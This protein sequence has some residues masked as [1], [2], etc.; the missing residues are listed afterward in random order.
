MNTL[1]ALKRIQAGQR[2]GHEH[3][4]QQCDSSLHKSPPSR[5]HGSA[6]LPGFPPRPDSGFRS[7]LAVSG[8]IRKRTPTVSEDTCALCPL[9]VTY[10]R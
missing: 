5:A 4:Q 8:P 3:G 7:I 1:Q 2:Q 6:W 10:H 9:S